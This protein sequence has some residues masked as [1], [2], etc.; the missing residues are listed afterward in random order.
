MRKSRRLRVQA[1][2]RSDWKRFAVV[3]GSVVVL[4]VIGIGLAVSGQR[5]TDA[6]VA[7]RVSAL[8]ARLEEERYQGDYQRRLREDPAFRWQEVQRTLEDERA[9]RERDQRAL[10]IAQTQADKERERVRL[11]EIARL[12]ALVREAIKD[13]E[14]EVARARLAAL[15]T[16]APTATEIAELER[17]LR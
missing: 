4:L 11:R 14:V 2:P 10:D 15:K 1:Q 16:T 3:C 9:S 7:S 8:S 17:A 12:V 6:E 13:G 5:S